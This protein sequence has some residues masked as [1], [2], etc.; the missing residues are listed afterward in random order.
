MLASEDGRAALVKIA[1]GMAEA[2]QFCEANA[3][4]CVQLV[5]ER[6][7]EV[8]STEFTDEQNMAFGLGQAEARNATAALREDQEGH[9]GYFPES[10][11]TSSVD[12]LVKT[13]TIPG[14]LPVDELY[15][16]EIVE[17]AGL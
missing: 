12:F 8:M 10:V 16:N 15:T 4:E 3:E 5:F 13:G 6:F 14:A 17:A 2:T 9:Y 7:P 1:K 11:W